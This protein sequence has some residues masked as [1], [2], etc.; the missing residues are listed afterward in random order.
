MWWECNT[1]RLNINTDLSEF[2]VWWVILQYDN[3]GIANELK[4]IIQVNYLDT[5][6]EA[7]EDLEM[8][9]EIKPG[10]LLSKPLS[11]LDICVV[12]TLAAAAFS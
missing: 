8:A 4:K 10:D 12:A 1:L 7:D 5:E 3:F 9:G 2:R 11:S 6:D